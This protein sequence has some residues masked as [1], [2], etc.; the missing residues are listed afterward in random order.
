MLLI[1]AGLLIKFDKMPGVHLSSGP[2]GFKLGAEAKPAD[3]DKPE[4]GGRQTDKNDGLRL[5]GLSGTSRRR[6]AIINNQTLAEG[7]TMRVELGGEKL[8][9]LCREIRTNSVLVQWEGR[10]GT[11]ELFLVE[12]LAEESKPASATVG[13]T[14]NLT[15]GRITNVPPAQGAVAIEPKSSRP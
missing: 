2:G 11:V 13:A 10:A 4:T 9:V 15:P 5:C 7:E 6:L 8:K 14:N 3:K 12:K 1:A